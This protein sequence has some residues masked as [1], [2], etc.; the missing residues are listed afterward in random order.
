MYG[1][2]VLSATT[3]LLNFLTGK[4]MIALWSTTCSPV[5]KPKCPSSTRGIAGAAPL[6]PDNAETDEIEGVGTCFVA[7]P[8]LWKCVEM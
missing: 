2:S 5:R 3:M 8:L 7:D 6:P 4:S 1:S